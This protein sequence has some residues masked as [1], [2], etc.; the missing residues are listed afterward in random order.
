MPAWS[1]AAGQDE[2]HHAEPPKN[3]S[4]MTAY[5]KLVRSPLATLRASSDPITPFSLPPYTL[6]EICDPSNHTP[7]LLQDKV[8]RRPVETTPD[9]RT[10]SESVGMSQRCQQYC[11]SSSASCTDACWPS[12][13][14]M[15][16]AG[17]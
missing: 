2:S 5:Q 8:L 7:S 14:T 15:R 10:S 4:T 11:A 3:R 12:C 16:Y 13:E 17:A 1:D 6:Y 9:N